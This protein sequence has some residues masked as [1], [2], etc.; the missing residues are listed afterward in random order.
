MFHRLAQLLFLPLL[1][2]SL[3]SCQTAITDDAK[4]RHEATKLERL[5]ATNTVA[6]R[7]RVGR[8]VV[9]F[10]KIET[11]AKS[12]S[13]HQFLNFSGGQVSAFCPRSE[14]AKFTKGEPADQFKGQEVEL[15]GTLSLYKNKLQI[16]LTNPNQIKLLAHA[17][18]P[19]ASAKTVK[20]KQVGKATWLSPAGLTYKGRDPEGRTRVEHILRHTHDIP[21]RDGPH[22]VFDG[23]EGVAFAVIDEAWQL[24]KTKKLRA[25][26]EGDRSSYLVSMRRR[27]GYLGGQ[28]GKAR[29]NPPLDRVFIVFETGTKNII[30]AFPR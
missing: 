11:T 26:T 7:K 30:T 4:P 29:G 15:T 18:K 22:G 16:K 21:D 6:M 13:G 3:L 19:A 25:K 20:L 28:V 24:A 10:G 8:Q 5:K 9:V 12:K 23:G 1:A 17:K 27:V 2:T 14:V